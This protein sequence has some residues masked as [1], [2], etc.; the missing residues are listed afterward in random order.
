MKVLV[1]GANGYIGCNVVETLLDKGVEVI[2]CDI[3]LTRLIHE[4]SVR[5]STSSICQ[6]ITSIKEHNFD[7]KREYGA[8]PDRPYNSP[9]E[10]GYPAKINKILG[11]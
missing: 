2:A 6:K 5:N 7:I 10:Y 9:C 4:Q 1:T 3:V 11:K 8:F